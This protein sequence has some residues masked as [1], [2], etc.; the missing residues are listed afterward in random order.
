MNAAE[1]PVGR[2]TLTLSGPRVVFGAGV[3]EKGLVEELDRLQ[4]RRVLLVASPR[5]R[6]ARDSMLE[7]IA[8]RVVGH[9]AE[10]WRH[11]PRANAQSATALAQELDADCL[12]SIG[13]GSA[14]GT[15]KA[16][17]LETGLPIL[18]LPTTYAGS[19]LTPIYG[20]TDRGIKRTG[21]SD[22]VLPRTVLLDP[23]L[24]SD[25]P[26]DI[27]RFSAV[28][29]L[30][31]C[32][33]AVFAS[34]H[35]PV[36]D[37]LAAGG[38]RLLASGLRRINTDPAD[39]GARADLAQGAHLAGTV[40]AHAGTSAH[41]TVCHILGGAFDLPH[42]ETHAAILPPA[43]AFLQEGAPERAA[44]LGQALGATD[45]AAAMKAL[46][47]EVGATVR[48]RDIGLPEVRLVQAE[49]L[50]SGDGT[51]SGVPGMD[52]AHAARLLEEAW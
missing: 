25:L 16:V 40:L 28:N 6:K 14:V 27:T 12:L 31:H 22:R 13:G 4:A 17:A 32:A 43:L 45:A 20:I 33:S 29:A 46:L 3:A 35:G 44:V 52:R 37:L 23:V 48:L 30:A 42:A 51:A 21:R 5:E 47:A 2:Y 15:A 49:Q 36:T 39:S 41:H 26:Q 19:E 11:V 8:D 9:V 7:R 38:V 24:S 10:V 34:G 1:N 50:L 18:A